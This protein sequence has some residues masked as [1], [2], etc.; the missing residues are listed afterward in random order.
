[1]VNLYVSLGL[2]RKEMTKIFSGMQEPNNEIWKSNFEG[3]ILTPRKSI[4]RGRVC[5]ALSHVSD[6][7][8]IV[9]PQKM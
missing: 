8:A 3:F 1:M 5:E 9:H 6:V 7:A 2:S 4:L